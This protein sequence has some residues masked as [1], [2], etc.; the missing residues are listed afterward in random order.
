MLY[1]RNLG[2][3]GAE[4]VL[5][6]LFKCCRTQPKARRVL[7]TRE[8]LTEEEV[9]MLKDRFVSSMLP[10]GWFFNGFMYLNYEGVVQQ[11]HP[12]LEAI[13]RTFVDEQNSEIGD[14][15]REVMKEAKAEVAKYEK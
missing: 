10:D 9:E 3:A 8:S 13:I 12:N 5:R 6:E 11:E 1:G 4:N 14:F 2:G 7:R 15:N